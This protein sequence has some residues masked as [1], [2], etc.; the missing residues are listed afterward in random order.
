MA[1]SLSTSS[2]PK[3]DRSRPRSAARY[4]AR[5]D[6]VVDQAAAV[7]ARKGFHGT[8]IDDLVEATGLH[9]GGL[10]YYIGSKEQLLIRIHERFIGPLLEQ[11]RNIVERSE[12]PEVE[13][14]L[15]A[16]AL[17]RDIVDYRDQVT[18]F[19][20][21]WKVVANNPEWQD[22]HR[23][24]RE[25]ESI[26]A[27][28]IRRG[29]ESGVFRELDVPL[30]MRGFLG[31]INYTYMWLR[32][33]GRSSAAEVSQAFS[34]IFLHGILAEPC[35]PDGTSKAAAKKPRAVTTARQTRT[36]A[37]A[38]RSPEGNMPRATAKRSAQE[39]AGSSGRGAPG[40]PSQR[41]LRPPAQSTEPHAN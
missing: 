36:Q 5:R 14:R 19:L 28:C 7:F 23:A 11:A 24:R 6:Q 13:L 17:I 21:E 15:L 1:R 32:A 4:S 8:S 40:H 31:M 2:K 34:D 9:R 41:A 18:V 20:H 25:F 29:C 10:Y 16:D 3:P 33:E 39:P 37:G 22:V 27:T 38:R 30:T 35:L 26:I 12:P